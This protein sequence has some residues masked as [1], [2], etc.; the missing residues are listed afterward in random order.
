MLISQNKIAG[1]SR[2]L[3]VALKNGASAEAICAKLHCAIDG[4]YRPRSGWTAREFDLAFLV[5]AIGGPQLLYALQKAEGY[6]S[7]GTL[8]TRKPIPELTISLGIPSKE[9][10]DMNISTLLG[11]PSGRKP[12]RSESPMHWSI[13]MDGA[14]IE[15]AIRFDFRRKSFLG[16]CREHSVDVK[17]SIDEISDIYNLSQLLDGTDKTCHYGKEATV[18]GI[19]PITSK[20]QYHITPLILSSSCKTENGEGLAN[21]VGNFIK[22]YQDHP[23]G[24]KRHGPIYTLA[25]DGESSFRKL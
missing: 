21:W 11:G 15:E 13:I 2:I 1:V 7:L 5:K 14:A 3:T 9:D 4:T 24:E 12:M 10:F 16:L 25:T 6:P 8:Q 18:V 22:A 19:A 23:D 17:K 20:E